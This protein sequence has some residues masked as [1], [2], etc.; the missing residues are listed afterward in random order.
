MGADNQGLGI[1]VADAPDAHGALHFQAVPLKF[2]AEGRI[3]D[4][5]DG[6]L[7]PLIRENRHAAPARAEMGMIIGAE[8]QI[9]HAVCP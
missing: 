6:P 5:V 9:H 4:V 8:E 1:R 7:D 2:G 3:F